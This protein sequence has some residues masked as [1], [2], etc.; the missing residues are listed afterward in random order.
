M[1]L[2]KQ[3][4]VQVQVLLA[5][6]TLSTTLSLGSIRLY[7][8]T[9]S[10]LL[11]SVRQFTATLE[12][13]FQS[14][15]YLAAFCEATAHPEANEVQLRPGQD[16]GAKLIGYETVRE[17]GGMR[18]EARGLGFTYPGSTKPVLRDINL[19]IRPGETLAIVGFNGG[20]KTSLV[21]ALMGLYDHSGTLLINGHES[22]GYIP[23]SLHK[24]T[25][26]LFQDFSRYSLT[27]RENVGIG[28]VKR[29][30]E[31]DVID[32]AIERGGAEKVLEKVGLEG[33]LDRWGVPDAAEG[34]GGGGTSASQQEQE[35]EMPT[36][37]PPD[38][39]GRGGGGPGR[40]GRGG[41]MLGGDIGGP[42][43]RDGGPRPDLPPPPDGIPPPGF[44]GGSPPV[45]PDGVGKDKDKDE[46]KRSAL[47]G[48]QWQRVA[49]ARAFLRAD[50]AD[51]I[52]FDYAKLPSK[53]ESR[54]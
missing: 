6:R 19:S 34:E 44:I 1:P 54:L 30:N 24:R 3:C 18:I 13:S 22:S 48:G 12:S 28:D 52:V 49:L 7:Q 11:T 35:I 8:S 14:T 29:L 17:E 2:P 25:S 50:E 10:S 36:P 37:P 47:S 53:V 46:E 42:R 33:R 40:G 23:E 39:M 31:V 51:L 27:L 5:L 16:S 41:S 45:M 43:R 26:C 38:G 20:G 32:R 21:K 4:L 9:A 15:F